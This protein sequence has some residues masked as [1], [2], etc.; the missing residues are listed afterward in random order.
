MTPLEIE[1]IIRLAGF[2]PRDSSHPTRAIFARDSSLLFINADGS[3][4]CFTHLRGGKRIDC[5]GES[6][7]SLL[8][9]LNAEFPIEQNKWPF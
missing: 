5:D 9:F 4:S 1:K 8:H 3:W 2:T 7:D 6:L